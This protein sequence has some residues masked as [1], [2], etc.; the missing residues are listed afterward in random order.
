MHLY[1]SAVYCICADCTV[2]CFHSLMLCCRICTSETQSME[3]LLL[4]GS[5]CG[6]ACYL[7][8]GFSC[9]SGKMF[10]FYIRQ[11]WYF[12]LTTSS[13]RHFIF[14]LFISFSPSYCVYCVSYFH[15]HVHFQRKKH[16]RVAR[17]KSPM[18]I[19]A[20]P[21]D[22]VDKKED[23]RLSLK[24]AASLTDPGKRYQWKC[25]KTCAFSNVFQIQD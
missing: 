21:S 9:E 1:F 4:F 13:S 6:Y 11:Q 22:S 18:K 12:K 8:H 7:W 16:I 17:S 23:I 19:I 5:G 24:D 20:K 15:C 10:I 25:S 14:F 2:A 3:H